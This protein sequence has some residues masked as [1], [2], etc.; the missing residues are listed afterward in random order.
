MRKQT[1]NWT[2]KHG[3]KVRICDMTDLHLINAIRCLRR[4][5]EQ[6][7]VGVLSDA[8]GMAL[9]VN[10]DMAGYHAD[11]EFDNTCRADAEDYLPEI[12][13]DLLR[14]GERR[15]MEIK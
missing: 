9:S 15:G 11:Q 8:A 3:V 14:D 7:K 13:W 12:Y 6:I 4:N 10:G 2:G 1:K 5:A